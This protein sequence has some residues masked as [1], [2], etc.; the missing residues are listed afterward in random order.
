MVGTAAAGWAWGLSLEVVV[1]VVVVVDSFVAR[2]PEDDETSG[3]YP[4]CECEHGP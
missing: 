1:V 4:D 2:C 3:C